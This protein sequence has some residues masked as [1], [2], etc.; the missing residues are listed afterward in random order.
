MLKAQK[1]S[2]NYEGVSHGVDYDP[3][4]ELNSSKANISCNE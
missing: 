2:E 4:K 3:N 1:F